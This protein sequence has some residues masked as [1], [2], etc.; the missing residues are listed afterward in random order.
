[1][2]LVDVGIMGRVIELCTLAICQSGSSE[3]GEVRG[4]K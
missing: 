4:L 2:T 1:M 3:G